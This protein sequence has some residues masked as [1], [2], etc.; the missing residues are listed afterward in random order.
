M[1]EMACVSEGEFDE[2]FGRMERRFDDLDKTVNQRFDDLKQQMLD[3]R[4]EMR[5]MRNWLVRLYGLMVFSLIGAIMPILF[6]G[7]IFK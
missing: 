2:F 4:A 5:Q 3:F 7:L 1:A 6:R